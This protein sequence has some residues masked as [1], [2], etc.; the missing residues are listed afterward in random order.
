MQEGSDSGTTLCSVSAD[1]F[2]LLYQKTHHGKPSL[3]WIVVTNATHPLFSIPGDSSG[4]VNDEE[5]CRIGSIV[6]R[7][8][9]VRM[10]II[11]GCLESITGG[12]DTWSYI[13]PI[14]ATFHDIERSTG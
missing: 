1:A 13:S 3:D 10:R 6:G 12:M 9:G 8:A 2:V 7:A 14:E 4:W 11:E 5:G